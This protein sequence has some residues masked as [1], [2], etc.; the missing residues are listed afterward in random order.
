[1]DQRR[2]MKLIFYHFDNRLDTAPT[3]TEV[4]AVM[5]AATATHRWDVV[6]HAKGTGQRYLVDYRSSLYDTCQ[7]LLI[8]PREEQGWTPSL[9]RT[10]GKNL[11]FSL[12]KMWRLGK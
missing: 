9:R 1:M 4:G 7:Y 3:A 12:D 6:L 2:N 8:H 5:D 10:D 11:P